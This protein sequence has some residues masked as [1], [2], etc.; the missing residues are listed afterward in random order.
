MSS[1]LEAEGQ[2]VQ[3]TAHTARVAVVQ[4]K[5]CKQLFILTLQHIRLPS[6]LVV[7]HQQIKQA[8]TDSVHASE[9][10]H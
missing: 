10:L 2:A 7:H 3:Q 8:V 4:G 1:W 9:H 5:Y 6:E